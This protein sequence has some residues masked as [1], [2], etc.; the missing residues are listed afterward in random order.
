VTHGW[1][2]RTGTP[3]KYS[4]AANAGTTPSQ[5]T[6]PYLSQ[7]TTGRYTRNYGQARAVIN[8]VTSSNRSWITAT[9][10]TIG[11]NRLHPGCLVNLQGGA[12]TSAN[13]GIWLVKEARHVIVPSRVGSGTTAKYA[14]YLTLT[15]N[16]STSVVFAETYDLSKIGETTPTLLVNGM[17]QSSILQ[18]YLV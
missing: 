5:T 4:T 13:T 14:S 15:R 7:V 10:T 12:M 8:A 2:E 16:S 9:A 11:T 6:V 17:W 18:A 1:D 3:F